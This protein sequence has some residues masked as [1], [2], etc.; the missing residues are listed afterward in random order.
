MNVWVVVYVYLD[1]IRFVFFFVFSLSS[2]RRREVVAGQ[3]ANLSQKWELLLFSLRELSA[4]INDKK[5]NAGLTDGV[6]RI[7]ADCT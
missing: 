5:I 7:W 1:V 6:I 4:Q 3:M 2:E